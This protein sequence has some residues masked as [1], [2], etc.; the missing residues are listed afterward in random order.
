MF[1]VADLSKADKERLQ[2]GGSDLSKFQNLPLTDIILEL[3]NLL[4]SKVYENFEKSV[5][6]KYYSSV[7]GLPE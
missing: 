7:H 5:A 4:D 1:T 6:Q 2:L 3:N